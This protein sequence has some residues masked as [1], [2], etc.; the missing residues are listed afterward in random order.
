MAQQIKHDRLHRVGV[1]AEHHFRNLGRH[2]LGPHVKQCGDLGGVGTSP[3]E[4][5]LD[6]LPSASQKRQRRVA[7]LVELIDDWLQ[8]LV[9]PAFALAPGAQHSRSNLALLARASEQVGKYRALIHLVQLIRHTWHGIQHLVTNRTNEPWCSAPFLF[10]H[11][12]TDWHHCLTQIVFA[13]LA[14]ATG[15]HVGD[16]I[17]NDFVKHE[18]DP[19]HFGNGL[20]G[21]VIVRR[22]KTPTDNYRVGI[23][24]HRA[25]GRNNTGLVVTHFYLQARIHSCCC[26]LLTQ[27]R[28][29]GVDNLAKQQLGAYGNNITAHQRASPVQQR[30][31]THIGHPTPR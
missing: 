5:H 13:H 11:L 16:A 18:L 20:A 19:H 22:P 17:G 30:L 31:S 1:I 14:V 12:S 26:Q 3:G 6:A 10:N 25:Q 21:D 9:Q 29:V 7:N 8:A 28:R 23:A 4:P 27:P 24:Q 15:K 2:T